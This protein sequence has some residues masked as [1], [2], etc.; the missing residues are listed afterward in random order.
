[1]PQ[2]ADV[3]LI[4]RFFARGTGKILLTMNTGYKNISYL[5]GIIVN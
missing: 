1:M 4:V 5:C 2:I 3:R